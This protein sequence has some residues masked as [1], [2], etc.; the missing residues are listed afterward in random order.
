MEEATEQPASPPQT[1]PS[2]TASGRRIC[3]GGCERPVN[4]CLCDKIPSE[5]IPTTTKIVVL[6]HPHELRHKLATVPLISKC[7]KNCHVIVGRKLRE[8]SSPILDSVYHQSHRSHSAF[9]LFPGAKS[10]PAVDINQWKS[11]MSDSCTEGCVMIVFDGTWKHA[12]EMMSASLP[13]LSKFATCVQF[14]CDFD[15][16]GGSI[17]DSEL[18]LRKEPYRGCMSTMEA[19][20]RALRALEP[21]GIQIEAILVDVLKTM[22][23]LQAC[24]LKH[25]KPRPRSLKKELEK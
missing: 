13:F 5:L 6:Q 2:A 22:V 18:I 21:D 1:D 25:M 23:R 16:S 20:A 3:T 11:S 7:L 9:F 4:V 10:T 8:G 19:V 14:N 15:V 24:Y 17:Y 12:K